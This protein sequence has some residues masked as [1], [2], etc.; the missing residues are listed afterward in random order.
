ML[1]TGLT[2]LHVF[3]VHHHHVFLRLFLLSGSEFLFFEVFSVSH[4][5]DARRMVP[6][7][8]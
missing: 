6:E 8:E 5:D 3:P 7:S 1:R 2:S 4:H